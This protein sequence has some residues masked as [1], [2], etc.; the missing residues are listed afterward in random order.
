MEKVNYVLPRTDKAR[1]IA[2]IEIVR[3]IFAAFEKLFTPDPAFVRF[4][5][6]FSPIGIFGIISISH[7]FSS[8][9]NYNETYT[10]INCSRAFYSR[11]Q[12]DRYL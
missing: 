5:I 4:P 1:E 7:I 2:S 11:T 9:F 8:S 12:V 3:Q 6:V 10:I